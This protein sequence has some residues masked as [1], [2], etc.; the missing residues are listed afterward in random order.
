MEDNFGTTESE[1]QQVKQYVE[2]L[3]VPKNNFFVKQGKVCR[4]MAFI[5]EGVM[6]YCTF[7]ED[8]EDITCYFLS[9]NDFVGDPDSFAKQK[10]SLLNAQA[11]TD[12]VLVGF[13]F[14]NLMKLLHEMPRATQV[15]NEISI[16][17]SMSLS[18]QKTFMIGKDA[19]FKY[20]EFMK[21]YP[22]ILQRVPLS[23]IASYLGIKQQSLS[24]LRKQIF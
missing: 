10:P 3:R 13:S 12:C 6:R 24:R 22:H 16:K 9:E 2:V 11:L 14:E 1:W 7:R 4:Y 17:V 23:Y 20:R 8:G 21:R 5:A 15:G 18:D 19:T